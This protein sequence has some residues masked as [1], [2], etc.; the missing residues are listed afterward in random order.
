MKNV[1]LGEATGKIILMGEHAVVYGEPAIAFPFNGTKICAT[2]T[3]SSENRLTSTYH[4]GFLAQVASPL[5]NLYE[6]TTR[7]Q[8]DLDTPNL[9]LHLKST[10]PAERGM[11]SSAAVAV[12]I[13]RAFFDWQERPLS[14]QELSSYVNFSEQIAHGNPSGIDAA[15]TSGQHPIYFRKNQEIIPFPINLDAFLLVADTG[16]KGQTRA[17]VQSVAQLA[18]TKPAFTTEHLQ[19]LGVLTKQAKKAIMHNQPETLGHLMTQAHRR[20]SELEVSSPELETYIDIA[21]TQGALGAKLTGGGRGGCLIVLTKTKEEALRISEKLLL[22]GVHDTWLQ[23]LGVY[24][25]A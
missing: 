6:L 19:Q 10:I 20:L 5:T 1:G 9:H 12:A 8:T 17:A 21:L 18:Q 7:L 16:I 2:I 15:T 23:G 24:Q 14:D 22:A 3:Q 25:Y 4:T 13:T 11:G